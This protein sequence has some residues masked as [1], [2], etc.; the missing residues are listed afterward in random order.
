[1]KK[2]SL[3]RA[4]GCTAAVSL[5][6]LAISSCDKPAPGLGVSSGGAE[7]S[8]YDSVSGTGTSTAPPVAPPPGTTT[9]PAAKPAVVTV[10]P[11]DNKVAANT[12]TPTTPPA[13]VPTPTPTPAPTVVTPAPAPPPAPAPEA[14]VATGGKISIKPAMPKP[15]FAGTPLPDN[16][17]PPNLDK[18]GKPTLEA[19]VPEG[20]VLLSKGKPVTT[21]DPAPLGDTALITDGDKEGD[22]GYFVDILPGKQWIQVDL[23]ESKEIHLLWV[24]HYHKVAAIYKDVVAQISDDP[25]FKTSTTVYNNDF[26]NSS[27]FGIGTDQS[28]VETN[29]GRSMPVKGIKGRY[30][31]LWSNGRNVDDTNHYI[32]VEV[33]GK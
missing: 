28:W 29:N 24:W 18:S 13:P 23:G 26:D 20:V 16:N 14:P 1:M 4:T 22:D 12:T 9:T 5:A 17:P 3:V 7:K 32:E 2:Q 19:Q 30:V 15:L 27:G 31:R 6:I 33:Y 11:P 21:S 8:V 10:T 25:E